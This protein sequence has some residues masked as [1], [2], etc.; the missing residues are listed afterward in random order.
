MA[1]KIGRWRVAQ[2]FDSSA[3]RDRSN[4]PKCQAAQRLKNRKSPEKREV[5]FRLARELPSRST[6]LLTYVHF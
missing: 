3:R 1:R 2:G 4:G 6:A 5:G